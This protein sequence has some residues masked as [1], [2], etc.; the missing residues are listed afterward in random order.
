V[1]ISFR[2]FFFPYW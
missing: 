1:V 2:N